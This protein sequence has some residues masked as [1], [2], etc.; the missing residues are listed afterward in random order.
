MEQQGERSIAAVDRAR[1]LYQKSFTL[2][3]LLF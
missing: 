1:I 3:A 2:I